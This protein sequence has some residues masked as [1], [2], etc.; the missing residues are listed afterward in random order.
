M[1]LKDS[2]T[3][4]EELFSVGDH[5]LRVKLGQWDRNCLWYLW[6]FWLCV[7]LSAQ[8]FVRHYVLLN[9]WNI[10]MYREENGTGAGDF[11]SPFGICNLGDEDWLH[12]NSLVVQW[13]GLWAFTAGAWFQSLVGE[14]RFPK[15]HD[16]AILAWNPASASLRVTALYPHVHRSPG[17]RTGHKKAKLSVLLVGLWQL[18]KFVVGWRH[19]FRVTEKLQ[20][21]HKEFLYIPHPD[22]PKC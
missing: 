11:Q 15:L 17:L 5:C 10:L 4:K 18:K 19:H 7:C 1:S 12:G 9:P 21:Q 22:F 13:L 16:V 2:T 14:L 6:E 3:G 20:E 8:G